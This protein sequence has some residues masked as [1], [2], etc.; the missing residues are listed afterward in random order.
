[1]TRRDAQ[2]FVCRSWAIALSG[3][4]DNG[5]EWLYLD[6]NGD[7]LPETDVQRIRLAVLALMDELW[8]RGGRSGKLR[9]GEPREPLPQCKT[10]GCRNPEYRRGAGA[11]MLCAQTPGS[12]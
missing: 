1:M 12:W 11:C 3:E 2:R 4:L 8:R 5:S 7:E 10:R 6:E 9:A